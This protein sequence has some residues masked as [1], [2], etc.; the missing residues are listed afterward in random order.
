MSQHHQG[1]RPGGE[2]DS[3]PGWRRVTDGPRTRRRTKA[4]V[5][6]CVGGQ[7][8]EGEGEILAEPDLP[9]AP[10]C[11]CTSGSLVLTRPCTSGGFPVMRIASL[12][13]ISQV[14][15]QLLL[16]HPPPHRPPG[17]KAPLLPP[18]Q[19]SLRWLI[20]SHNLRGPCH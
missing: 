19:G 17:M 16:P 5:C 9:C 2:A 11:L 8:E 18:G 7:R 15:G 12:P 13:F 1:R 3:G 6:A 4:S 10:L 20:C 14:K